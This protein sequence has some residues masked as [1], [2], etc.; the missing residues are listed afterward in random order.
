MFQG[1]FKLVFGQLY[2]ILSTCIIRGLK[3]TERFKRFKKNQTR[4][5]HVQRSHICR[6]PGKTKAKLRKL[7]RQSYSSGL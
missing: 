5:T 1:A 4:I 6:K 7:F 2:A 3:K